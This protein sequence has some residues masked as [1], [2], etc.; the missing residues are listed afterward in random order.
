MDLNCPGSASLVRGSGVSSI[1]LGDRISHTLLGSKTEMNIDLEGMLWAWSHWGA[2]TTAL[3]GMQAAAALLGS[4]GGVNNLIVG[5]KQEIVYGGAALGVSRTSLKAKAVKGGFADTPRV[6]KLLA[7]GTVTLAMATDILNWVMGLQEDSASPAKIAGMRKKIADQKATDAGARKDAADKN[8]K[9]AAKEKTDAE[10]K[11]KDADTR[12]HD[13]HATEEQQ[14]QARADKAK[15]QKDK[16]AAEKKGADAKAAKANATADEE[17]ANREKEDA[18]KREKTEKA[19]QKKTTATYSWMLLAKRALVNRMHAFLNIMEAVEADKKVGEDKVAESRRLSKHI[20]MDLAVGPAVAAAASDCAKESLDLV[21]DIVGRLAQKMRT[22]TDPAEYEVKK[23]DFS[24][25][26]KNVSIYSRAENDTSGNPFAD[27]PTTCLNLIAQGASGETGSSMSSP[28]SRSTPRTARV[29]SSLAGQRD[30]GARRCHQNLDRQPVHRPA[31]NSPTSPSNSASAADNRRVVHRADLRHDHLVRSIGFRW[32]SEARR[33]HERRSH[34]D[35]YR[36]SCLGAHRPGAGPWRYRRQNLPGR[37]AG[38]RLVV[39][40]AGAAFA[41][42]PPSTKPSCKASTEMAA[43]RSA[44]AAFRSRSGVRSPRQA[45][46]RQGKTGRSS[47]ESK[48]KSMPDAQR[49]QPPL[50]ADARKLMARGL[51]PAAFVERLQAKGLHEDAMVFVAFVLPPR[52]RAWWGCLCVWNK[53]RPDPAP[54]EAGALRAVLDW[55]QKP[56]DEARRA[57]GAAARVAGL[58]T[59][60]G[61]VAQAVFFSGGSISAPGL[62]DVHPSPEAM[63]DLIASALRLAAALEDPTRLDRCFRHYVWLASE[64]LKRLS[65][66]APSRPVEL[67]E[68]IGD[69]SYGETPPSGPA[70]VKAPLPPASVPARPH[71]RPTQ[72]PAPPAK[73]D[74]RDETDKD[75]WADLTHMDDE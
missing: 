37:H 54:P 42:S 51:T 18:E 75:A 4:V 22:T 5:P 28:P 11:E 29:T 39:E 59:P 14:Q 47:G 31:S 48:E 69:S 10:A 57:S 2:A 7:V 70:P 17:Q 8:E 35:M 49:P 13:P 34:D 21:A 19:D 61:A 15:A 66:S 64:S 27:D 72:K 16:A 12:E 32:T 60:A 46:H 67:D 1:F 33:R 41:R 25:F 6:I 63:P 43:R 71:A 40:P 9:A 65:G 30:R 53:A 26:G 36:S 74:K 73:P 50:S 58:A 55:I 24:L 44:S 45:A 56:G 38:G 23:G 68:S 62:P 3:S 52:D 20:P